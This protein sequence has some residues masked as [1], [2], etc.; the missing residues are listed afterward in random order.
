LQSLA[1]TPIYDLDERVE[2]FTAHFNGYFAQGASCWTGLGFAGV[3][4]EF[5]SVATAGYVVFANTGHY[6]PGMSAA[7]VEGTESF[8]SWTRNQDGER[9]AYFVLHSRS[10]DHVIG[11]A[12]ELLG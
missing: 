12:K 7:S 6:A 3:G 4:V 10:D 8:E 11:F 2:I 9:I 5:C 1:S